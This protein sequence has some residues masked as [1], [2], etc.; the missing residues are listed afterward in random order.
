[1]AIKI[2]EKNLLQANRVIT[3]LGGVTKLA[4]DL[5]VS[6]SAVSHWLKRGIPENFKTR[7][8]LADR[9]TKMSSDPWPLLKDLWDA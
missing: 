4:H 7:R 3:A 8:A 5:G 6:Q 9:I 1:M 2:T